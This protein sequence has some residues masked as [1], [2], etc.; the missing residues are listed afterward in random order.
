MIGGT[1]LK[2]GIGDMKFSRGEGRIITYALGS[3]IGITF[4]DPVTRLGALLHIM[5]PAQFEGKD[6][7]PF[8][9]ADSGIR[10]TLRKLKIF[11]MV[12]SRMV[13]K[14]A[15]GAKMF[16]ISG[17]SSFGN[18]GQRNAESVKKVMAQEGIC[19]AAE[20]TGG[21][22]ARTMLL[23]LATC[24]RAYSGTTGTPSIARAFI[25]GGVTIGDMP[26]YRKKERR[27][28][29]KMKKKGFF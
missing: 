23:D 10:E 19:I 27:S 20:D 29:S 4:Y 3:C 24:D 14:I 1:E 5:L 17:N 7:N 6:S 15:G 26:V 16:E 28:W 11:G 2:V 18:I 12:K 9:F 8:K 25:Y 13:V 21:N 22:Y